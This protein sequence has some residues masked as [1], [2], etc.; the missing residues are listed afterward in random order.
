M[1]D[2]R[3]ALLRSGSCIMRKHKW[4][5]R[6][7][8]LIFLVLIGVIILKPD[9]KTEDHM[10]DITASESPDNRTDDETEETQEMAAASVSG[11]NEERRSEETIVSWMIDRIAAGEIELSE[12]ASIRQALDEAEAE[13]EI[14]LTQDNKDQIVGFLKTLGTI[15]VETEDFIGQAKE[16]YQTYSTG[17]VEEANEAINDAV[18]GAVTSAARNFFDN[19][20]Q[21]AGDF[22]KNLIP[23]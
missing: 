2:G 16:K 17:F 4:R 21:A 11:E 3:T 20:R 7:F 23:E 8:F 12:E 5:R 10:A 9:E 1:A 6:L 18:E 19:I 14:S 15:G 13:L 22:F